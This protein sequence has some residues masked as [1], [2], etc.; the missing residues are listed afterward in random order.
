MTIGHELRAIAWS[1][2]EPAIPFERSRSSVR[3]FGIA[4]TPE[5]QNNVARSAHQHAPGNSSRVNCEPRHPRHFAGD[6]VPAMW[7]ATCC[8]IIIAS[9]CRRRGKDDSDF[10]GLRTNWATTHR[11]FGSQCVLQSLKLFDLFNCY[12]RRQRATHE[13]P[14]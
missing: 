10:L 4:C 12:E 7:N 6:E 5:R 13:Y 1:R 8:R 14:A 11:R 9:K 2:T 3:G